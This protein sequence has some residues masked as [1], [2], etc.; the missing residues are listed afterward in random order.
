VIKTVI[1][2][3]APWR[4]VLADP[5]IWHFAFHAIPDLP[6]TLVRGHERP[7]F[8]FFHNVLASD[9]NRIPDAVRAEFASAYA[10]PEALKAGFDWYRAMPEEA[11]RNA[12]PA[13]IATPIL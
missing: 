1:P 11:E 7:Y 13:R 4:E 12:A 3:V 9:P 6:E 10:R 2:G 5:R 8:D